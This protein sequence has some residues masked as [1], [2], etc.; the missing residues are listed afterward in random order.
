MTRIGMGVAFWLA[1]MTAQA[2]APDVLTM[3]G[4]GRIHIG[5][6]EAQIE[7]ALGATLHLV[8]DAAGPDI[9]ADAGVPGRAGVDLMFEKRR[10]TVIEVTT[11]KTIRTGDGVRIG[12][13]EAELRKIFGPRAAFN[14][15]PYE[16]G[17]AGAHE[18]IVKVTGAREF[19]FETEGGAV[20]EMRLGDKPSTE[21]M[22]GCA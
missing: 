20:T 7:H 11:D 18:V 8:G 22:E 2:A 5:M 15:R 16:E 6:T 17:V 19:V 14:P 1:A 12:T 13:T 9:C 4:L 21:Y 10:L 3:E